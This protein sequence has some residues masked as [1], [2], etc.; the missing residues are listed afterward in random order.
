MNVNTRVMSP[1]RHRQQVEHQRDVLFE[2]VRHADWRR[3][4]GEVGRGVLLRAL[5]PALD[6]AQVLEV[7]AQ[8]H[9]VAGA[10][11]VLQ[12]GRRC[13]HRIENAALRAHP[14]QSFVERSG[15]AEQP[16]EDDAGIDL[17]GQRRGRSGPRDRVHV[18]AAVAYVARADKAG[19]VLRRELEGGEGRALADCLRDD[20]I[21]GRFVPDVDALGLLR[22]D[23]RQ[24]HGGCRRVPASR[25][26]LGTV[27]PTHDTQMVAERFERLQDGREIKPPAFPCRR[28]LIEDLAVGHVD[29]PK[30][31]HRVGRCLGRGRQRGYHRLEQRERHGDAH[32]A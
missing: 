5:D 14:F 1:G 10:E 15:A 17:H 24:P 21:D 3:G 11:A 25:E 27:E 2:I 22:R 26:I 12:R 4:N 31:A 16:L 28:P 9:T 6:F 13:R 30:S 32:A 7:R 18:R 8:P 20:L 23:T 29:G 19:E